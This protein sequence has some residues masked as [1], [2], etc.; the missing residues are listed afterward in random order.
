MHKM[1]I[2]ISIRFC[3]FLVNFIFLILDIYI[4]YSQYAYILLDLVTLLRVK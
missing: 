4:L 2:K 1:G 3:C